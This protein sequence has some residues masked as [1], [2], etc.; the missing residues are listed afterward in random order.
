MPLWV[1]TLFWSKIW[2]LK[3]PCG[4]WIK[5]CIVRV[6]STSIITSLMGPW[7]NCIILVFKLHQ[8]VILAKICKITQYPFYRSNVILE[9]T[10][11]SIISDYSEHTHR[12]QQVCFVC[13]L[14]FSPSVMPFKYP[15]TLNRELACDKNISW[16]SFFRRADFSE[17]LKCRHCQELCN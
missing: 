8:Y 1:F 2:Y 9:K 15:I 16:G 11:N 5:I 7:V 12:H 3:I 14:K 10:Q 17:G 4:S 6:Q 13:S